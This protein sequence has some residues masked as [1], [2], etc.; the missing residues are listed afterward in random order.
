MAKPSDDELLPL[1]SPTK[2]NPA[3]SLEHMDCPCVSAEMDGD[4]R[5]WS[6]VF[7]LSNK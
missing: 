2:C 5:V 1:G 4:I 7:I 3:S 6:V